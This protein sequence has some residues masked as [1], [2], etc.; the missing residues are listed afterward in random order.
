MKKM[1]KNGFTLIELL[2]VIIILGVLLLI[3]VP[4]V[5]RI[6]TQS[7]NDTYA[8]NV[9]NFVDAV[10]NDISAGIK[11]LGLGEYNVVLFEK[12]E[13]DKGS[14]T[15]SSFGDEY[16]DNMSYVIV[17]ND[18]TNGYQYW[19]AAADDGGHGFT[20]TK[21]DENFNGDNVAD[22][23]AN[24]VALGSL[25][26]GTSTFTPT[27]GGTAYTRDTDQNWNPAN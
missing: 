5:S 19:A 21:I 14:N 4:S 16:T 11:K 9:H 13:L 12:I 3:A 17:T 8:A 27:A 6:I 18:A 15:K 22:G 24:T 10:K 20:L 25:P 7:R 23:T 1:N 26:T 2:A